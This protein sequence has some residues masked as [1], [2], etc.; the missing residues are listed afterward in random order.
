MAGNVDY[1]N[2][3][4]D[5]VIV[6]GSFAGLAVAMQLRGNRV[7]LVDQHPI[8]SHQ[9]SACGTP[10]TTARAVGAEDAILEAHDDLVL[11]TG[12]RAIRF[13]LRDSYVTFDYRLFC[14]AMAAQ[15]D[16]EVWQARSTGI[17]AHA[18]E[19]TKGPVTAKFVVNA[20]GWRS[21]AHH[22]SADGQP[23]ESLG[24]GLETELS[25]NWE[26]PG[27]HFFFVK[28][29]VPNGYAW[30]FPCGETTRFGVGTFTKE[31]KLRGALD[32]FLER[33]SLERGETHGGVLAIARRSPLHEDVFVVGDAAGQC[34]PVTGEG[35][36]TAI[37]HG[38]HC[39]RA[40]DQALTGDLTPE[41]ARHLYTMQVKSMG[42]FHNRLLKMQTLVART[43]ES[44]LA[45]AGQFCVRSALS[46]RLIDK[47]W[48]DTGWFI[49]QPS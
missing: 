17:S 34:L 9:M 4:Y 12:R 48:T 28:D 31:L 6:G 1:D 23:D 44:I 32:R 46:R 11:H 8:G 3:D 25:K 30:I 15:T 49:A 26:E 35:I 39:G 36:R 22:V 2:V 20:S 45:L 24:Y 41:E 47:Y 10:R 40:I 21:L 18:V 29:L 38:L 7:L 33:Y 42:R 19:T 5:V 14:Q 16:A 27:L 37:F 13:P 43:P